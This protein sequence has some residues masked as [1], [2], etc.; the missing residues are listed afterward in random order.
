M[1]TPAYDD[2][3]AWFDAWFAEASQKI[4]PEPNAMTLATV[5]DT[6]QPSIRVVLLKEWDA[7]GFVFYTNRDSR[8]GEHLARNPA[9]ALNFYW[10]ELGRQIR[11]EGPVHPV[12]DAQSD[13]Y[14][15]SRARMSQ[16]GAWASEQSRELDDWTTF[17]ERVKRYEAHFEGRVVDRPPHWGGYRVVPQR[18]EFWE[19]GEF[20]LHERWEFRR[21]S[22]PWSARMLYP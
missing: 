10:R 21:E 22:G 8:K 5:D 14:F 18:I 16:I 6:G 4:S 13:R 19:S 1:P 3:T 20:R 9:A 11:I 2:P 12:D 15:A 17:A 7:D